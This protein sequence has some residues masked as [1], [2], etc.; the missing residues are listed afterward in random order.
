MGAGGFSG[1]WVFQSETVPVEEL[2]RRAENL[3]P[4][5]DIVRNMISG[6]NRPFRGGVH[7]ARMRPERVIADRRNS[8]A[9]GNSRA[10]I[11]NKRILEPRRLFTLLLSCR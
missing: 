10:Y 8:I 3:A 11:L 5:G 2:L 9:P 6:V 7:P 4:P 1:T